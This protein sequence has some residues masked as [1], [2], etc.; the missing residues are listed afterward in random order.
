MIARKNSG[1]VRNKIP[2]GGV[3]PDARDQCEITEEDEK[4]KREILENPGKFLIG[5]LG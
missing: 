2:I 5:P 3:K 4:K 1:A